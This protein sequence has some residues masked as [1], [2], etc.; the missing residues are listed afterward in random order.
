MHP[1]T[2]PRLQAAVVAVVLGAG[3]REA[4]LYLVSGYL[5]PFGNVDTALKELQ[6]YAVWAS[7]VGS[8]SIA[9]E[10]GKSAALRDLSLTCEG[11]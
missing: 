4:E 7:W 5:G 8:V 9:V 6:R 11:R 10:D 2:P 3:G 1:Y